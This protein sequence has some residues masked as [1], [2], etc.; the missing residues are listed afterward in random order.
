MSTHPPNPNPNQPPAPG[1]NQPPA[2]APGGNGQPHAL[3]AATPVLFLPVNIETRFMDA[4]VR[5]GSELWL[6]VYPD[7]IAIN[8]HEPELTDQ[9]IADG[10]VYWDAV[11]R[12]G[13]PPAREEDVK[14]PWRGLAA[15]YGGPRAAWIALTMT[16]TNALQQPAAPTAEGANPVPPPSYRT[17]PTH[18]GSWTKPAIAAAL[19]DFWKVAAISGT[20]VLTAQGGPITP[21][22]AVGM[23]PGVAFP[24]GSPVD[25]GMQWLVDFDAAVKAGMALKIPLTAQQRNTGFDRIFVYG[26]RSRGASGS[27]TLT[28][29]LNAHHYTDGFS[30]VAQG[31]PTNNT[32]D[33]D[34]AYSRKDPDQEA[35]YKVERSDPLNQDA[36]ADGNA[37]AN[38]IGID[39][40][41]M[42]HVGESDGTDERNGRDM[43][44]ALWPATLGY[45]FSQMMA[46]VFTPAQIETARQYVL[47]N[48][49]PRGP[50]PAFRVGRTPYGVL[51]I[52]SLRRYPQGERTFV[53]SIEPALVDFISK[54]WPTWLASAN[55]AP[56]M[57]NSGDPDAQLVQVLGMDASSMT[58]RGRQVLG[59]DFLWNYIN[60]Q[61]IAS[62]LANPWW[63]SHLAR[64]RQLLDKFGFN[65][66]DPRVI[67][68]G[69]AEKSYPVPFPTV[70]TGALSETDP[71]KA[72]ADL[73]GGTKGNYIRWLRQAAVSDIQADNYPGPK[74]TA[75]LYKILRQSV[76]LDYAKLATFA[77]VN[78]ARLQFAQVREQEIIGVVPQLETQAAAQD[79]PKVSVWE[80]L[81]RPSIPNPKLS[82]A[83]YLVNLDPPP[84]SPFAQL[85]ELRACLDRL[86]KLSTAELDRLLTETLDACS[87]RLDVWATAIATAL[88]GRT[89]AGKNNGVHLG[90]F[91]WV[92]EVRPAAS[93]PAV[94][95]VELDA[96]RAL[97]RRRST[98]LKRELNLPVPVQPL[99][100]NGGYIF[101]PSLTQAATAAVLRNGYMTHKGTSQEGLLSI[102]LS[103]ERVRNALLLLE[104]VQQGQSLN[105]LLGYLFESGLH[106]LQ[107]DKYAQPFRDRFPIVANKLT[108]SSD[109]SESVAAS[110]VVDGLALRTAWDTGQ[111]AQGGNWGTGLPAPGA[112]QNAVIGLLETID[113]Y[114]DALAD[115]SISE[116]VFQI[117]RG[118][119]GRAG[120]LMDAISKGVRPPDPDVVNTPRGGLDL[121][122]RVALLC[123]GDPAVNAVWSGVTAH[124]RA[125]A[126][127]WLDAWVS[128]LLP[129]PATVICNVTFDDAG[130]NPNTQQVTLADL[131]VGPLDVIAMADVGQSAQQGELERR[132]AF[133]A[134]LPAGASNLKIDFQ[135]P[136]GSVSFPDVFFLAKSLRSLISSARAL[137]PQDLTRPEV[138]AADAGGAVKIADLHDRA[139]NAVKS[140][141]ND[142]KNLNTAVAGLPGAPGPVRTALLACSSYGVAGSIPLSS[143]GADPGLADQAA[144]VTKQLQERVDTASKIN[145]ATA[146][147]KADVPALTGVLTTIFGDDFVVLPRF[148]PPDFTKLK[149][150]FGQ[151][152][153]LVAADPE[154]PSR[155]LLQLA[156][157]RP[158]ISRLDAALSLAELLG[159]QDVAPPDL[160]LGQLPEVDNDKWL[161]LGIDTSKPPDKGRVAFACV[162]Q[163]DPVNDNSYAGLLIDEW[164]ERIPSTQE[165]AAVAFHYEEPKARAPQALL[166]AVCPDNRETWDD[167]LVTGVLQEALELA[168]IRT[169]DLDSVQEA[170]QILPALYFA[171][172]LQGATVST[173]FANFKE[174]KRAAPVIR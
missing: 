101:A 128:Q 81:A 110:N 37:F 89:R 157:V 130:G 133:A 163:G 17:P 96:V 126:E 71:L 146:L 13:K 112:D 120:T 14:A 82:W 117:I 108:P 65:T 127:P 95:G 26:L 84:Q 137:T 107:L 98:T 139:D 53:G 55:G 173:H 86:A 119:F 72:D 125:A 83:E 135:A 144:G 174:F 88:L 153:N 156:H 159:A 97:D 24:A 60:F 6:R 20:A 75:L 91:G 58:F 40:A 113:D 131:D 56:H 22:L 41:T 44:T 57:Q 143:S 166:L 18:S 147:A 132:I 129:D 61:G 116:A 8:S 169:V 154:A 78:A 109:P 43:F 29:L 59:D 149:A 50:L 90:A 33:A 172:N 4:G 171:L 99:Q 141:K 49:L 151:S 134:A 69:L 45:F 103:S 142:L 32:P 1:P 68:L 42:A 30:L 7:Q 77:E 34:A 51:P 123:A 105:A 148:T 31:A 155:W 164:P 52:T 46:D 121:T 165:N 48:A 115:L 10:K 136:A 106:T 27:Q 87:H 73:G 5:G 140:L 168:K 93:R 114:A 145:L 102:D 100:D 150:A 25:P 122:H 38:L 161:G 158:G 80:V 12:A 118:N 162:T 47:A 67:H 66:W 15:R 23:T 54:L 170:G 16:P 152:D 2:P 3:D 167:D 85:T 124:P 104:G 11:W 160:L 111:L 74:P 63:L 36:A 62:S 19:P 35:S 21:D 79:L 92:E 94:V 39:P 64:G 76:L 70:Q 28:E 9:E 138:K